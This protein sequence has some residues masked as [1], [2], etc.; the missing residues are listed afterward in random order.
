MAHLFKLAFGTAGSLLLAVLLMLQLTSA[1]G[2]YPVET[3]PEFFQALPPPLPMSYVVDTLRVTISGGEASHVVRALLV[4]GASL[5]GTL[6]A[7]SPVVAGRRQWR[8]DSLHPS[9]QI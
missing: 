4:L 5:V 2:L 7:S 6:A 3:T 8:P 9:L 1:G